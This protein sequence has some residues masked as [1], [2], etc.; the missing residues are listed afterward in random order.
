MPSLNLSCCQ[1]KHKNISYIRPI[2]KYACATWATTRGA[3]EKL[4]L[5]EKKVLRKMYGPV[6]NN[7]EQKW[8]IRTNA[9][10]YQLHKREDVVQSTRG[11]RIEWAGHVWRAD[12]SMLKEALTYMTRG[13][14]PRGRPRKRWKDSVKE[15]L[16]E[17]GVDWEQAYDRERWK[18]VVL[19]AKSLNGS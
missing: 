11:T 8:E 19:A 5:F 10:L 12:G 15:L 1:E 13:K 6:F 18:E 9:Q 2:L 7:T 17:I 3:D 4:R 14:R 16:E